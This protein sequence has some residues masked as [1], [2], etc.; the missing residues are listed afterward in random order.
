MA[1]LFVRTS[2]KEFKNASFTIGIMSTLGRLI[3]EL[4]L[5]IRPIC[6]KTTLFLR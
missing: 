5:C 4:K 2:A 1:V 3:P 6:A